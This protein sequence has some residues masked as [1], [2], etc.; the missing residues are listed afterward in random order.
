MCLLLQPQR[1]TLDDLYCNQYPINNG[2]Q[3]YL[4]I[5][6]QHIAHENN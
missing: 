2:K 4:Y 1:G 3:N 6:H 5:L